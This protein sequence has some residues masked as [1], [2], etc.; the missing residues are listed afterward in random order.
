M[1]DEPIYRYTNDDALEDGIFAD[2]TPESMK[3]E[4][5]WIVTISVQQGLSMA[6]IAELFNHMVA[7]YNRTHDTLCTDAKMNEEPYW[8]LFEA[9]ENRRK[10]FKV[11]RPEEY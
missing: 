9:D 2:V 1:D 3:A 7:Y 11:I 6:A 8:L 10:I 4:W 5:R